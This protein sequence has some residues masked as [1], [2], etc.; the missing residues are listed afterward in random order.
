[1][2]EKIKKY[3]SNYSDIEN[4]VFVYPPKSIDFL[5]KLSCAFLNSNGGAIIFGINDTGVI[6]EI[7]GSHYNI[8]SILNQLKSL[9]PNY[10]NLIEYGNCNVNGEN[11]DY[12]IIE[13]SNSK[14]IYNNI[15]YY[16]DNELRAAIEK[17]D[18]TIFLSYCWSD[19]KIADII[20]N[21]LPQ[22]NKRI[23]IVRDTRE[24]EYK[25]SIEAYMQTIKQQDYV[26]SIISDSYLKSKNCMYEI[27]ELMRDRD[28]INKLLFIVLSDDDVKKYC[29]RERGGAHI[30]KDEESIEYNLFW[31]DA[32]KQYKEKIDLLPYGKAKTTLENT[33]HMYTTI[34]DNLASFL[35]EIK[36]LLCVNFEQE[37]KS[38][39]KDI[40]DSISRI[41]K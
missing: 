32:A 4:T 9:F 17:N 40:L 8:K 34:N 29:N 19:S 35:N 12:I 15:T 11:V 38:D 18:I 25:N 33:L 6:I 27:C 14:A 31:A 30:F 16:Y 36:T 1:M 37:I 39:Y 23:R 13:P 10:S 21:D 22:K 28:Y 24:L 7:K 20:D 3:L 2:Y 26:L 5:A 41:S